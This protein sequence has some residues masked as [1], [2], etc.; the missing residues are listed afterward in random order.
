MK[1]EILHVPDCPGLA[2]LTR[3]I[4]EAL[5]DERIADTITYRVVNDPAGAIESGMTGSPTL[6]IDGDDPF[7]V[8]GL[9]PSLSCR[10]YRADRGVDHA[11]SV[12]ELRA[13]LNDRL[14]GKESGQ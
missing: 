8:C 11:P 9:V 10:L 2:L 5:G 4:A 7:A 13:A 1:L 3:R 6:L 12:A 14:R